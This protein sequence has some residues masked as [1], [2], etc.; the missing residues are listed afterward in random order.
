MET[1]GII[2]RNLSPPIPTL[3]ELPEYI[4][5]NVVEDIKWTMDLIGDISDSVSPFI[6][7]VTVLTGIVLVS[8]T[9]CIM[10]RKTATAGVQQQEEGHQEAAVAAPKVDPNAVA[11]PEVPAAPAEP[12][13]LK[14]E[15]QYRLRIDQMIEEA[16]QP[17]GNRGD[18]L[19]QALIFIL[20]A[21]SP[22]AN[23]NIH[24]SV[25]T[26]LPESEQ[27]LFRRKEFLDYEEGKQLGEI[28][29]RIEPDI[30]NC[31]CAAGWRAL[32]QLLANDNAPE[33]VIDDV[34]YSSRYILDQA[35][36]GGGT[37]WKRTIRT[38]KQGNRFLQNP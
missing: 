26:T 21:V 9:A 25:I 13:G 31:R 38:I 20:Q 4:A 34:T 6:A 14:I 12:R 23:I 3:N 5:T 19:N 11:A 37:H 7:T 8:T 10:F 17:W 15:K 2:L 18:M 28:Q 30:Y 29:S 33:F 16:F 1:F 36:E 22:Q 24:Q 35:R 32:E 27:D